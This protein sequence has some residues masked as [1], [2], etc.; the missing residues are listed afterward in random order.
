VH[1]QLRN[2]KVRAT[3]I[4]IVAIVAAVAASAFTA[5]NTVPDHD[6]GSGSSTVTGYTVTNPTYTFSADGTTVTVAE[7]DLDK[8]AS[9][10]KAA[11]TATPVQSDWQD[12][13][14]AVSLHVTCT[15][16]TPVPVAN[17]VK[18]NVIAVSNGVATIAP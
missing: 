12:C 17:H 9:D 13:G 3:A 6:A 7:F 4:A 16:A 5:S 14:A 1:L 8:A 18:L 11:L 10:V 15:F 2:R